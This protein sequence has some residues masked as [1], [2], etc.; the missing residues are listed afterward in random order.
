MSTIACGGISSNQAGVCRVE[1]ERLQVDFKE[2]SRM[3]KGF[4]LLL[5]LLFQRG[6]HTYIHLSQE[7]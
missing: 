4:L 2:G 3:G 6:F 7:Q 1:K 5:L